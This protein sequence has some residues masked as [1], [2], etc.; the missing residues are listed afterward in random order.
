MSNLWLAHFSPPSLPP[1][2]PLLVLKELS[3]NYWQQTLS[4]CSQVAYRNYVSADSGY[5]TAVT[6]WRCLWFNA[7]FLYSWS[8]HVPLPPPSPTSSPTLSIP[9]HVCTRVWRS[10]GSLS[11]LSLD[12]SLFTSWRQALLSLLTAP[13]LLG[14]SLSFVPISTWNAGITVHITIFGS[15]FF[16]NVDSWIQVVRLVWQALLLIG[17]S[18]WPSFGFLLLFVSFVVS[19]TESHA[20]HDGFALTI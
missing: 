17:P 7:D 19:D 14:N 12:L 16:F 5:H 9:P 15:F 3:A 2:S 18:L 10:E 1:L 6:M 8:Y 13:L 11:V 4:L 20:S